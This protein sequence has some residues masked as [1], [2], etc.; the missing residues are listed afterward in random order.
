MGLVLVTDASERA[1]LAVIRSLGKKGI[2]VMA[3][4]ATG[5]NA[6]FLSKYCAYKVRAARATND[7][8]TVQKCICI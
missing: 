3:A 6:G 1:A 8:T 5:F 4:D 7:C 2:K